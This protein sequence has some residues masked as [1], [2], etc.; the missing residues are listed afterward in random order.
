MNW[1]NQFKKCYTFLVNLMGLAIN[2]MDEYGLNNKVNHKHLQRRQR[3]CSINH[4][5]YKGHILNA[6][7]L[8][9][10]SY[11]SEWVAIH[12]MN[13]L[14]IVMQLHSKNVGLKQVHLY[15]TAVIAGIINK[16]HNL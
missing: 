4:S 6:R 12:V 5:F 16:I 11:G 14:R 7:K 15:Y 9:A 1:V 10:V 3:R 8:A 2:I 13:G